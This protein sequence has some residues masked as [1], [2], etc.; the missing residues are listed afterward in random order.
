MMNVTNDTIIVQTNSIPEVIPGDLQERIAVLTRF[1][2]LLET[3][4]QKFQDYLDLLEKQERTI[5][6]DNTEAAMDYCALEQ[7]VLGHISTLEKVIIPME[8]MY[9]D[10]MGDDIEIPK[11]QGS[12]AALRRRVQKQNETNR[13][14]LK[15]RLLQVHSQIDTFGLFR[16]SQSIY[17]DRP[18]SGAFLE[19]EA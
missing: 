8:G 14:L 17:A 18:E 1:Y 12:L 11:L 2:G 19:I 7:E 4:R 6:C 3:Q 5:R 9:R 15:N 13:E 10:I 16:L